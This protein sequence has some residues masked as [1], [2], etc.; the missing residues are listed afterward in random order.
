MTKYIVYAEDEN[1]PGKRAKVCKIKREYEALDFIGDVKNL[2]KYGCMTLIMETDD[3]G[4]YVWDNEGS[5][6]I[7]MEE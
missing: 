6:W 1:N 5:A 2:S 7:R 4:R 3:D